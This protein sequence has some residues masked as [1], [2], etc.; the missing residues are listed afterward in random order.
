[1]V[2]NPWPDGQDEREWE[3]E[4][5]EVGGRPVIVAVG[6][7]IDQ[8]ER[9]GL[10]EHL[11]YAA[12]P[13]DINLSAELIEVAK[14]QANADGGP[15]F[16]AHLKFIR[17][18][19]G[20]VEAGGSIVCEGE[21]AGQAIQVASQIPD[22]LMNNLDEAW[23]QLVAA[24]NAGDVGLV[25]PPFVSI[26]LS[27]CARR[28]AILPVLTDM[29]VE[30]ANARRAI[31]ALITEL[32]NPASIVRAQDIRR[33]LTDAARAMDPQHEWPELVPVRALWKLLTAA[34]GGAAVGQL[35]GGHPAV[36]A[37]I[38]TVNQAREV[39][40]GAD[41]R[42]ILAR[43]AFDLARRINRDLREVPRMPELLRPL[44]THQERERFGI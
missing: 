24:A 31:W 21:T 38:G 30:Y 39:I 5:I 26:L 33:E 23:A 20:T 32:R 8:Y 19:V 25:V 18:L 11:D 7:V 17:L 36:G 22:E 41:P 10:I 28:D 6:P 29:K 40:G 4:E 2:L 42:A 44:L 14:A 16:E 3:P 27:R 12:V 43:G 35:A 9:L 15:Y 37:A 1:M 13:L 34:V